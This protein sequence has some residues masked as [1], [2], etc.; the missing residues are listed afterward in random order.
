MTEIELRIILKSNFPSSI[1]DRGWNIINF[2]VL[3]EITTSADS[4]NKFHGLRLD[5]DANKEFTPLYDYIMK[6]YGDLLS[7][8]EL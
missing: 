5:C 6:R 7:F 4:I 1:T 2:A 3:V 8:K